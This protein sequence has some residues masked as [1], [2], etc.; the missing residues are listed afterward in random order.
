M[1][2]WRRGLSLACPLFAARGGGRLQGGD[3][4]DRRFFDAYGLGGSSKL[5]APLLDLGGQLIARLV[6][7]QALRVLAA[8]ALDPEV[9]CLELPTGQHQYIHAL[10]LFD[11]EK[12]AAL[13]VEEEGGHIHRQLRQDAFRVL[14]HGLFLQDAEDGEGEGLDA[15]DGALT[16]ATGTD[17][18]AGL[19]EGGAQA[20][21]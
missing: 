6:G 2:F 14:L 15:A 10:A 16:L 13:F 7:D 3:L 12:G 4:L 5:K 8:D 20:L 11:F 18:L 9:W 1:P 19:A 21:A 17:E